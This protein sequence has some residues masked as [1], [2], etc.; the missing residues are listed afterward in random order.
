M[1]DKNNN[2][3]IG[4]L[5]STASA[6]TAES[7]ERREQERKRKLLLL[8]FGAMG[9]LTAIIII[10]GSIAWFTMSEEVES[11]QMSMGTQENL[12][13]VKPMSSPY[14]TGIYDD[15]TQSGTFVRN[16]LLSEASKESEVLTWTITDDTAF[17]TPGT[18]KKTINKGKNIGNG[19][20]EGEDGGISPGSSGELQFKIVPSQ[21]VDADFTFRFYAYS[22]EY[23]DNGVEVKSTI[24]LIDDNSNAERK[25][26]KN[27]LN[28]HI[29]LFK[30]YNA[31]TKKYSG[32]ISSD[33]FQRIMSGTY[34][35]ETTVSV[36]WV[37]PETLAEIILDD[38]NNAHKK[39]LKGKKSLCSDQS[40][41]IKLFKNNPSWF[42]LDPEDPDKTWTDF[43]ASTYD[44]DV[45]S[46]VN[47]NYTLYSSF[48]N[49]ADQCIGTNVAYLLLD[50]NAEGTAS[51]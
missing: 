24:A 1:S 14:H 41:V 22:V 34:T 40:E 8:K 48:Y 11:H 19:P 43:T 12:F 20:A 7:D 6:Y 36:H 25:L 3:N 51:A 15:P 31:T 42:L 27:L 26:A 9:I 18:N 46:A 39:N 47:N 50:M 37:W 21:S 29:L 45:V 10:I 35:T 32:L 30:N 23:D 38:T 13:T 49:E 28:G 44:A 33:D 4:D 5:A 16:T 17:I 2:F